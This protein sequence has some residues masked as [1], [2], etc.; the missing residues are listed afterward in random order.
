MLKR[1]EA[2][3]EGKKDG[4]LNLIPGLHTYPIISQRDESLYRHAGGCRKKQETMDDNKLRPG[5]GA[6]KPYAPPLQGHQATQLFHI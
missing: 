6:V 4:C 1:R 3:S 2:S 5:G